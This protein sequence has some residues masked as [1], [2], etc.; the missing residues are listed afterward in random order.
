MESVKSGERKRKVFAEFLD[1][2]T[3]KKQKTEATAAATS[4]TTAA[5]ESSSDKK[6]KKKKSKHDADGTAL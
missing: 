1:E 6:K 2:P 5:A 4:S 3:D